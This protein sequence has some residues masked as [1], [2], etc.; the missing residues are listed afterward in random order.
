MISQ[1]AVIAIDL[2]GTKLALGKVVGSQ[3]NNYSTLPIPI[4]IKKESLINLI[5]ESTKK[6]MNSDIVGIGIGVPSVVDTRAGVVYDVQN[7]PAWDEVPIKSIL[8]NVFQV[9]VEVN[10]DANCF[11]LGEMLYVRRNAIC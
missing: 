3:I 1:K 11:M 9:P 4:N 7:I 8:E 5:I 6:L 2:G 10:N